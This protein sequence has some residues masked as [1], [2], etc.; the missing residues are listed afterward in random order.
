LLTQ[1]TL[2]IPAFALL[3]APPVLTVWLP[4]P[5]ERSPTTATQRATVQSF[6]GMLEPRDV[7]GARPLDQ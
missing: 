7:V 4:G 1:M 6:G 3:L 2:L 5:K